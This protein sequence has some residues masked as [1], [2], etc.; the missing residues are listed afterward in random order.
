MD[1]ISHFF[2][3]EEEDFITRLLQSASQPVASQRLPH[4]DKEVVHRNRLAGHNQLMIDYFVEHPVY[5]NRKFQQ[6]FRMSKPMFERLCQDLQLHHRFWVQKV[7]SISQAHMYA[8]LLMVM[9]FSARTAVD[10]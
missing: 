1:Q 6:H 5:N 4:G 8:R 2:D 10:R 7:V 9:L 3:M